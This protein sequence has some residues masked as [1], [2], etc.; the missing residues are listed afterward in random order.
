ML[1]FTA[2]GP[3]ALWDAANPSRNSSSVIQACREQTS[4]LIKGIMAYPPP[5]VKAPIFR[6]VR[7]IFSSISERS[8]HQPQQGVQK[9]IFRI[10]ADYLTLGKKQS[11]SLAAGYA[12][13]CFTSFSRTVYR[14][15]HHR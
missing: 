10:F 2:I 1:I 14:T 13:I 7:K 15:A 9:L 4:R 8:P 3:G 5:M 11:L 6:K 12:K